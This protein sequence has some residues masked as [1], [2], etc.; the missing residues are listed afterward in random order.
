[1]LVT[2][3]YLYFSS[4]WFDLQLFSS[5]RNSSL[6]RFSI[7]IYI[8]LYMQNIP[9][10]YIFADNTKWQ[11][12]VSWSLFSKQTFTCNFISNFSFSANMRCRIPWV[13]YNVFWNILKIPRTLKSWQHETIKKSTGVHWSLWHKLNEEFA[14]ITEFK[15]ILKIFPSTHLKKSHK[16]TERAIAVS[17]YYPNV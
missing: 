12:H 1:M 9:N 2:V 5:L 3:S 17:R 13:G 10:T 11:N 16:N 4:N 15:Y 14:I 8:Y 7:Y 6:K